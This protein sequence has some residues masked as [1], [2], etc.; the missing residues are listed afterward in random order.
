MTPSPAAPGSPGC[1]APPGVDAAATRSALDFAARS[2]RGDVMDTMIDTRARL[3]A[4]ATQEFSV[5]AGRIDPETPLAALGVDSL[6]LM[7]F[8][9]K[10]ED[11]F[12]VQLSDAD[13][14]SLGCLADVDRRVTAMLGAVRA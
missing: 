14:R 1:D 11:E 13:V 5:D 9:F 3:T 2:L 7:E 10:V 6:A 4:L 8:V 12:G